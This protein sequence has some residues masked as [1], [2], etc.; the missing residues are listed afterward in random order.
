MSSFCY[1]FLCGDDQSGCLSQHH[2]FPSKKLPNPEGNGQ[3]PRLKT[4][5]F[6]HFVFSPVL[7][8]LWLEVCQHFQER[9]QADCSILLTSLIFA[10]FCSLLLLQHKE[11]GFSCTSN[12]Y[13]CNVFN[14]NLWGF[15]FPCLL[16][17]IV[18]VVLNPT[19]QNQLFL[20]FSFTVLGFWCFFFCDQH[21][22]T[23]SYKT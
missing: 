7:F 11:F 5:P 19:N 3:T 17:W 13:S 12:V 21:S 2:S 22:S 9:Q 10:G 16:L 23:L 8:L 14:D 15:F 20:G 6:F 1:W 18:V 4:K